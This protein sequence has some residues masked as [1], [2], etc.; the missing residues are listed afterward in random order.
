MTSLCGWHYLVI[1]LPEKWKQSVPIANSIF[2]MS[3]IINNKQ[4]HDLQGFFLVHVQTGHAE[5]TNEPKQKT[6]EN[7][8]SIDLGSKSLEFKIFWCFQ[9]SYCNDSAS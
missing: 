3:G 2:T 1:F 4:I 6:Q 8:L 5:S 7:L 9:F